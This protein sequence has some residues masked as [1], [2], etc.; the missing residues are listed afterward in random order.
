MRSL[1]TKKGRAESGLFLAEG[2]RLVAQG[3]E[4]GWDAESI[5]VSSDTSKPAYVRDLLAKTSKTNCKIAEV[6]NRL[7][8]KVSRKDNP[9]AIIASFR[10]KHLQV[11]DFDIHNIGL[12]IALYEVRDP[13]NLGTI[14]IESS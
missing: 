2:T 12:W 11:D 7:L 4:R 6:P 8:S 9:Q 13:G 3:I 5:L 1:A 10:Q 14:R